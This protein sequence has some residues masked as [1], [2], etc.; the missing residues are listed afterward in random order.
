MAK[1]ITSSTTR[2]VIIPAKSNMTDWIDGGLL[3]I[4]ATTTAPTK[5][6]ATV[7]QVWYRRVGGNMEVRY[8]YKQT[9]AGTAGSGDYLFKIPGGYSV[10]TTKISAFSVIEGAGIWANYNTVGI[11][12]LS[13]NTN[14]HLAAVSVY[15]AT[16]V[17]MLQ[18]SNGGMGV[19][20]GAYTYLLETGYHMAATF[21][22]PIVGWSSDA[23]FLAAI[24]VT[25]K[26]D[27]R[28]DT[29][30]GYG[31]TNTKIPYF[32]NERV[33]NISKLGTI[34]NDSTNGWSF[35]ATRKCVAHITYSIHY[36]P[37]NSAGI[38]LNSSQLTTNI[39]TVTQANV[40]SRGGGSGAH[41]PNGKIVM[42]VG[43]VIRP[44]TN[45]AAAGSLGSV[46]IL[47]VESY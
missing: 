45:G 42:E 35:T 20:G 31:S 32:T 5:G 25:I 26:E 41:S 23:T 43:D 24:P 1:G 8:E 2:H 17:R 18:I 37:G 7:D 34:V 27:Y 13:D 39:D 4:G 19:N 9:T 29:H 21:S 3:D 46:L 36:S 16:N 14:N 6:T 15:D 47:F 38:S 33:N 11:A 12:S 28:V 10:D 44:H 30:A 22:V 40:I